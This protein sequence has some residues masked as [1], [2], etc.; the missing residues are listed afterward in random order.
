MQ[1]IIAMLV[2]VLNI[3]LAYS[4][5]VFK[6]ESEY[7]YPKSIKEELSWVGMLFVNF[8]LIYMYQVF[9]S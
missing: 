7:K 1:I 4:I 9:V 5:I 8:A 6:E 3:Y 2:V